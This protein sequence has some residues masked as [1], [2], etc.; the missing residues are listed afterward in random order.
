MR[1]SWTPV[2]RSVVACDRIIILAAE[3]T[4]LLAKN[5]LE[6]IERG[7]RGRFDALEIIV[8]RDRC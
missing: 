1:N 4:V 3:H 2:A 6:I 5:G 8:A 7:S